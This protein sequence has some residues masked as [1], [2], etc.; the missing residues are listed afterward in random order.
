MQTVQ[1]KKNSDAKGERGGG[2]CE[3]MSQEGVSLHE[4]GGKRKKGLK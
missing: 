2:V 3:D 4:Q 1:S